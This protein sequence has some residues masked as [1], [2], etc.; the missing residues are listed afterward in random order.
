MIKKPSIQLFHHGTAMMLL[1]CLCTCI[2]TKDIDYFQDA[3]DINKT[4]M[5]DERH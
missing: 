5:K 3:E 2:A 4:A 1:A